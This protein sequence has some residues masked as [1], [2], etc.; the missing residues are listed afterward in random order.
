[1]TTTPNIVKRNHVYVPETPP[2]SSQETVW[3]QAELQRLSAA[4]IL[5]QESLLEI[6]DRL[7]A[8]ENP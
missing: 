4:T 6:Q 8:L 5:I 1:M 3:A 7:D 2:T